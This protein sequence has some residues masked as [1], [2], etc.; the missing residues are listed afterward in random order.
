MAVA[1]LIGIDIGTTAVKAILID[2]GG[3]TLATFAKGYPTSRPAPDHVE[4]DPADWLGGVL[5]ALATFSSQHDLGGLLGIGLCSQ[6]S[7]H[8]FVGADNRPLLPA[9]VWQD[10]R[11]GEDAAT[12]DRRITSVEKTAWFGGPMPI[13]ASHALSRMAYVARVS[14]DIY[15]RTRAVLLPKDYC[16]LELTGGLV[17]DPIAAVGLVDNRLAYLDDLI[18]LVPGAREKLPPLAGFTDRVGTI[19]DGLPG[20]GAPIFVGTMDAWSGMFG[21]GVTKDRDAMYLSGT[22]EVLGIISSARA[23]TAGVIVFPPYAGITLHVG[24]TQAGGASLA[25][26]SGI[27]GRSADELARLAAGVP[28]SARVPIFLP[29]LQ[30]ER[31]PLWDIRT[32]G[33]F[34]RLDGGSGPGELARALMEGVAFSARLAFEAVEASAG[35][36][37]DELRIGGGGARSDAWCQIRADALGKAMRRVKVL[38]AGTVGAAIIAGLGSGAMPSLAEATERL[39]AFDCAFE[40]DRDR[41]GYYDDKFGKYR[42]LYERLKPF[43]DG[44]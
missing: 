28:A 16:A 22:S 44:Y 34:A 33:V 21:V 4:Q 37:V 24:P 42:E 41:R 6:V 38:D 17:S 15:A 25:W 5:A 30:G 13:D 32:R 27:A 8:V 39:V 3:K 26:L 2:V 29:H 40:P 12:L 1:T 14:P 9:F 18:G 20:A 43:N 19:R 23:P 36:T 7:T 11:C 35:T 10:G 31:A